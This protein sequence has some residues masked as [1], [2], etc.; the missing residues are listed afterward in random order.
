M[1]TYTR[2][3]VADSYAITGS[4]PAQETPAPTAFDVVIINIEQVLADELENSDSNDS[5]DDDE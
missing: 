3:R 1:Q 4:Q 2:I 5:S